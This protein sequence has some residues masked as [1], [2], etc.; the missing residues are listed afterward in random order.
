MYSMKDASLQDRSDE[1]AV[2][3]GSV[4]WRAD[5][6]SRRDPAS[7]TKRSFYQL[8]HH[9][10][11]SYW[12]VAE[13]QEGGIW[14]EPLRGQMAKQKKGRKWDIEDFFLSGFYGNLH[15]P[16]PTL[17]FELSLHHLVTQLSPWGTS[18]ARQSSGWTRILFAIVCNLWHRW[19]C[20]LLIH[21]HGH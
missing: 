21:S 2:T 9:G 17:S 14:Y 12:L 15:E 7:D 6:P 18:W 8:L 11:W 1:A 5:L 20:I 10:R 16:K 13:C 3:A 4:L 19:Y